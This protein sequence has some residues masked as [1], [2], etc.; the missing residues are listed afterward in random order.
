MI[1]FEQKNN[2]ETCEI[3]LK[4]DNGPGVHIQKTGNAD[5]C[6]FVHLECINLLFD[7]GSRLIYHPTA[8]IRTHKKIF[9]NNKETTHE[10][11]EISETRD[12]SG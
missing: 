7:T 8:D 1:V 10:K 6:V 11:G 2:E 5:E 3:C 9:L 4:S 12:N